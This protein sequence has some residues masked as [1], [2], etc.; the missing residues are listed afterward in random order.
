[1]TLPP[2]I[3][4]RSQEACGELPRGNGN[5]RWV[6]IVN[7]VLNRSPVIRRKD[8]NRLVAQGRAAWVSADQLRL[9]LAHPANQRAAARAAAGYEWPVDKVVTARELLNVGVVRP[10][11]AL[12]GA[13]C[14]HKS[15]TD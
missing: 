3:R 9:N 7:P 12:G 8:A 5:P 2:G 10:E 13:P 15:A 1:M 11:K 6:R 4:P 14:R